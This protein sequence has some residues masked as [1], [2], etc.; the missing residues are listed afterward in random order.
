MEELL[1]AYTPALKSF[2]VESRRIPKELADDLLHDFVLNKVLTRRLVQ[3]ANQGKGKFRNYVLKALNNFVNTKLSR[4]RKIHEKQVEVDET[5][6]PDP[7]S[8]DEIACFDEKWVQ[9]VVRDSLQSMESELQSNGRTDLWEIF[10]LRVV[11]PMLNG[12]EPAGYNEIVR[13][14][15]I[16]TPRQAINLLATAKR[17]FIRH[18]RETVGRYTGDKEKIDNEIEDLRQIVGR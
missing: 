8:L 15:D 1:I 14:F 12:S 6:L 4:E 18:L 9:Q 17:C 11:E 16:Q 10:R 2:L 3:H 13:R 7:A 5:A